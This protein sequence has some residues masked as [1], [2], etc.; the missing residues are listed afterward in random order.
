MKIYTAETAR[1]ISRSQDHIDFKESMAT[2]NHIMNEIRERTQN[3][4][5]SLSYTITSKHMEEMKFKQS[6]LR[7]KRL[8]YEVEQ[9]DV[10]NLATGKQFT[11]GISW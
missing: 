8:G 9:I 11:Y 6:I 1:I 3:G 2:F 5:Y 7:L 4:L 10:K